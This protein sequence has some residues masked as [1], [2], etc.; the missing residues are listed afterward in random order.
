MSSD[1]RLAE[2]AEAM[3]ARRH[4]KSAA[5]LFR[6]RFELGD[7]LEV[8][9]PSGGTLDLDEAF[10]R[11]TTAR[12]AEDRQRVG[13]RQKRVVIASSCDLPQEINPPDVGD[14]RKVQTALQRVRVPLERQAGRCAA[15]VWMAGRQATNHSRQVLSRTS[16]DDIE[17]ERESYRSVG[18]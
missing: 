16:I 14:E 1:R 12:N 11:Q 7:R 10:E 3:S 18:S 8:L 2:S 6:D 15:E 4:E 5:A 13:E 17:I 9:G